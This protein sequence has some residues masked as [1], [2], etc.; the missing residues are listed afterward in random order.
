MVQCHNMHILHG[1]SHTRNGD[2]PRKHQTVQWPRYLTV[3][4]IVYTFYILTPHVIHIVTTGVE[5]N[6]DTARASYRS[7]NRWDSSANIVRTEIRMEEM[8]KAGAKR[9]KWKY[10]KKKAT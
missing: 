5:R 9:Q 6:N 7:S 2:A 8:A 3:H 4:A 10:N 1:I